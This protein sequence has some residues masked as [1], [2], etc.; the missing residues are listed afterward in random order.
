M[1][2]LCWLAG[3]IPAKDIIQIKYLCADWGPALTLPTKPGDQ[4]K[5][6]ETEEEVYFLKQVHVLTPPGLLRD[7]KSTTSLYLCKMKPDGSAK[8]AIKEL[9][10]NV[11]YPIDTQ[12]QAS[13]LDVNEKTKR[14][15]L[16]IGFAGTDLVGLW[17]MNLDGTD[18]KRIVSERTEENRLRAINTCSWTPD[19]QWIVFEEELRGAKPTNIHRITKCTAKGDTIMRLTNGPWQ[20][21]PAVSPNGKTIIFSNIG[22]AMTGGLY[23]MNIDGSDPHLLPNPTDKRYGKHSG[24]YPAWSPDG[25]RI[26]AVS[27]GVI[28]VLT[29]RTLLRKSPRSLTPEGKVLK[30]YSNVVMPHWGKMGLLCSGWGGGITLVDEQFE[31]QRILATTEK[32][33]AK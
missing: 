18:L 32:I 27:A 11:A 29:G 3:R 24:T 9:W 4:P 21:Q 7:A 25:A 6:S 23:L 13:W 2:L 33:N 14:I 22:D 15:A 19:G 30:E 1:V 31:V 12:G 20:D 28:D 26:Y 17:V 10:H 8:T 5:Y 16:A